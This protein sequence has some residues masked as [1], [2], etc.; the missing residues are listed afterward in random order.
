MFFNYLKLYLVHSTM[1]AEETSDDD[2]E[3]QFTSLSDDMVA[4]VLLNLSPHSIV[5]FTFVSAMAN[6]VVRENSLFFLQRHYGEYN[7]V[8]TQSLFDQFVKNT[9]TVYYLDFVIDYSGSMNSGSSKTTME[10]CREN[11]RRI[12][13]KLKYGVFV[14]FTFFNNGITNNVYTKITN[15]NTN[16]L[17]FID[18]H[19]KPTGGRKLYDAIARVKRYR[20]SANSFVRTVIVCT[21]G[22]DS[23][24]N[25]TTAKRIQF[26]ENIK[27]LTMTLGDNDDNGLQSISHS[28]AKIKPSAG[29]MSNAFDQLA[30][31]LDAKY[32]G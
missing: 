6:R 28:H 15:D 18:K 11:I 16:L 29:C 3:T 4:Q 7:V 12:I 13:N 26:P 5:R 31:Q 14:R 23:G 27:L 21:S 20:P 25:T 30:K 10:L 2:E 32:I 19:D 24:S 17:C 1:S 9:K 22:L 8:H